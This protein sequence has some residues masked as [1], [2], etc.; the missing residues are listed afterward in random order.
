MG[1]W[2][3]Q[4]TNAAAEGSTTFQPSSAT[5]GEIADEKLDEGFTGDPRGGFGSRGGVSTY[6]PTDEPLGQTAQRT[7]GQQQEGAPDKASNASAG[8]VSSG[9]IA[10]WAGVQHQ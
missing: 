10:H 3:L 8:Y 2:T 9:K 4:E 1:F 7:S 5:F 6:T